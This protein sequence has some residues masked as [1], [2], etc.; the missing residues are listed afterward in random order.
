ME[1]LSFTIL[2]AEEAR[3]ATRAYLNTI[4]EEELKQIYDAMCKQITKGKYSVTINKTISFSNKQFLEQ[5]GYKVK[6]ASQYNE[7]Y[8]EIRWSDE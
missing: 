1:E 4:N 6:T 7:T 2:T 5:L 8:T 3:E